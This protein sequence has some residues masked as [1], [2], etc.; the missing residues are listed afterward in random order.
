MSRL[1]TGTLVVLLLVLAGGAVLV[2]RGVLPGWQLAI[3]AAVL[4]VA[5]IVE[6]PGY[7]R[8]PPARSRLQPTDECVQDPVSGQVQRVWLDPVSGERYYLPE[9]DRQP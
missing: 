8:T 4:A 6:R 5:L 7:Q 1:R 9:P 2:R 3:W